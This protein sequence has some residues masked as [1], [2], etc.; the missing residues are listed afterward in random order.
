MKRNLSLSLLA[1]LAALSIAASSVAEEKK[2]EKK[3][4]KKGTK[5]AATAKADAAPKAEA[6]P[7]AAAPAAPAAP[8]VPAD[9]P[10][11][12]IAES[13]KDFGTVP[14]GDD[15]V[16]DYQVKNTGKTDLVIDSV[17]PSCGCTVANF[18]KT[19]KAGATGKISLK[20]ETKNFSGPISKSAT[21][22][23][24]DPANPNTTLVLKAVVKPYVDVL[25]QQYVRFSS[26]QGESS[27]QSV[28][29]VTE[30]K[31]PFKVDKIDIP[32]DKPWLKAKVMPAADKDKIAGHGDNTQYKVEITVEKDAPVGLLNEKLVAHTNI[33]KAATVDI[34]V[35]GLVRPIVSVTPQQLNFG[36]VTADGEPTTRNVI[37]SHNK[38]EMK[39]FKI[40]KVELMTVPPATDAKAKPAPVK[41]ITTEI[42][43][44]QEG[45]RYQ[46]VLKTDKAIEKGALDAMLTIHTND[47]ANPKFEVPVKG[48]V[49]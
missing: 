13:V 3:A 41:G 21:V 9:A 48:T 35:S 42:S 34:T 11:L 7:A 36:N 17:K 45:Q 38:E 28:T 6:A 44:I 1:T 2:A 24:N 20:V 14:K 29:L 37:V 5:P 25:P 33:E 30:E 46:V 15:L 22:T 18:D 32:A 43:A 39:T 49:Q 16:W 4:E 8:A 23:S 40:T 19:I 31:T 10:K 47:K 27:V 26:L 12:V